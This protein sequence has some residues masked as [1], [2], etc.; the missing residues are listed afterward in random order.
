[1]NLSNFFNSLLVV[2]LI[3][4]EALHV[5]SFDCQKEI[6]FSGF[7][8]AYC[9]TSAKGKPPKGRGQEHDPPVGPDGYNIAKPIV[10]NNGGNR[11]PSGH[12]TC[13]SSVRLKI[14]VKSNDLYSAIGH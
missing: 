5:Q 6:N 11:C 7:D 8:Q 13:C 12:P 2:I 9:A 4:G 1:M 3:Q 10:S 14:G